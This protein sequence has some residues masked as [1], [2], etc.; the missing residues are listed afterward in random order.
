MSTFAEF[1]QRYTGHREAHLDLIALLLSKDDHQSHHR[2][3][4]VCKANG[5]EPL[6]TRGLLSKMAEEC[7][8]FYHVKDHKNFPTVIVQPVI[9]SKLAEYVEILV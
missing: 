2:I 5:F 9:G 7:L 6:E 4:E 8:I 3:I 1:A